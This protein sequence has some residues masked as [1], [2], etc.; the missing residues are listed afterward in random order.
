MVTKAPS[1]D[2]KFYIYPITQ[3]TFRIRGLLSPK[4]FFTLT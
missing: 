1:V 3:V 4:L 2:P